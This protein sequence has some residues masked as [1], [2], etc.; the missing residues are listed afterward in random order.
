M[1][2]CGVG[3][4]LVIRNHPLDREGRPFPTLFWLTCPDAVRAVSRLEADGWI[5]RLAERA[6]QEPAFGQ[7]LAEAHERH[8]RERGRLASEGEGWGGVAGSPGGVKCLHAHYANH[9]AGGG[10]PVGAWVAERVEPVHAR[11][12]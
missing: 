4:P 5:K 10:D 3:H 7:E 1:A 6:E 8:A 9:L 2:R 12:G 11:G